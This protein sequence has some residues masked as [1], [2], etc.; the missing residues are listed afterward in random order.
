M[1][2]VTIV[3]LA[4]LCTPLSR[5]SAQGAGFAIRDGDY[6]SAIT[7][8]ADPDLKKPPLLRDCRRSK[9]AIGYINGSG[10]ITYVVTVEGRADTSTVKVV[11]H[12]GMSSASLVSVAQRV[13]AA[14]SYYPAESVAGH[15]P[16]LVAQKLSFRSGG[17]HPVATLPPGSA[18][19]GQ[20]EGPEDVRNVDE[21]PAQ[22][23]CEYPRRFS[24]T[25]NFIL[26]FIVGADGRV[27]SGSI[28]VV[29]SVP[30]PPELLKEAKELELSCRFAPGRVDGVP[31]RT[32]VRQPFSLNG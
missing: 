9:Q 5:V 31:V 7:V 27:E 2:P 32:L 21:A 24:G 11:S 1:K 15:A 12:Q 29:N 19:A 25:A 6:L 13:L 3:A 10:V 26:E 16:A 20:A 22:L 23:D 18:D 8:P 28:T 4:I 30:P 17:T 14:C